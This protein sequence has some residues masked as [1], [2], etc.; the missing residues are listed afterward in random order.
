MYNHT[1]GKIKGHF[2]GRIEPI[3]LEKKARVHESCDRD[4]GKY[5]QLFN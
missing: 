4:D 3:N 1:N 5:L 2:G